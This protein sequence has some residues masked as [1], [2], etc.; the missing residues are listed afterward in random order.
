MG[1][2]LAEENTAIP[3]SGDCELAA[4]EIVATAQACPSRTGLL[5]LKHEIVVVIDLEKLLLEAKQWI[6]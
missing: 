5:S 6:R 3:V 2:E 4:S 1:F